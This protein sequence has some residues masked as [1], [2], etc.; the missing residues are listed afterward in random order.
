[1]LILYLYYTNIYFT[2]KNHQRKSL[3][4]FTN[5][6][7]VALSPLSYATQYSILLT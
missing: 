3:S 4:V 5:K 6:D 2:N 1:M 7:G